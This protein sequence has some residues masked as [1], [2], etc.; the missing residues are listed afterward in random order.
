MTLLRSLIVT[1]LAPT[2][3]V[4]LTAPGLSSP[5]RPWIVKERLDGGNRWERLGLPRAAVRAPL[6]KERVQDL[7]RAA[8]E[9]RLPALQQQ[10]REPLLGAPVRAMRNS[11]L[12][13]NL[14]NSPSNIRAWQDRGYHNQRVERA[15]VQRVE[16]AVRSGR[17]NSGQGVLDHLHAARGQM[18]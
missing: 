13:R 12:N 14:G 2:L 10:I 16:R 6:L 18:R 5:V 3:V 4:G 7:Q 17:I 11:D 8:L 1:T 15:Y 9:K